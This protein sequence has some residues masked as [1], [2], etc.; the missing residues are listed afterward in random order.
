MG[1]AF[2][3]AAQPNQDVMLTH[4]ISGKYAAEDIGNMDSMG[5]EEI[6]G[7]GLYSS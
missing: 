1:N 6:K 3:A 4:S 5:A 7:S 2:Y